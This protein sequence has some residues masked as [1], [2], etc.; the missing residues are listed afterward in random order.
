MSTYTIGLDFGTNSARAI[1]VDCM[2]GSIVGSSIYNYKFGEMGIITDTSNPNIAR[3]HPSDYI[4]ALKKIIPQSLAEANIKTDLVKGIGVDTT[5]STPI[6]VD[7]DGQA[8]ALNSSYE[9]NLSAM[10]WLWKDHTASKEAEEITN[11]AKKIRPHYLSKCGG[12]YSSEWYWAKLLHCLRT[13]PDVFKAAYSWVELQDW[14]PFVLTGE[15]TLGLCAAGHKGLYH[16]SWNGFP[17]DE[18]FEMLDPHLLDIRLTLPSSAKH[19]GQIAGKL[20]ENWATEFNLPL[21]TPVATGTIDA[22]AG[23][24]GSGIETGTMVKIIGTSTCDIVLSSIS[25]DL[26]EIPGICGIAEESVLPGYYGLEAGQS[27][28]G[29]I[30]NWFIHKIEPGCNLSHDDLNQQVELLNPG[31]SGLLALDWN[32]GNRSLLADPLLSGLLIGTTLHTTPAEIF[33]AYIEATAFGARMIIERFKEYNILIDR[34]INCGGIAIKSSVVMQIYADILGCEMEVSKNEQSCALGAAMAGAVVGNVHGDFKTAA[35]CMTG[36]NDIVY[37]PISD[38][39]LIYD[40]LYKMYKE[41]H[42]VF[43]KHQSTQ[44]LNHIMKNLI[45]IREEVRGD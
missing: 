41:L 40:K 18:F 13:A 22:H 29:D 6:P 36:T 24:V 39:Q 20:N 5:A 11:L 42:D 23:A 15:R 12:I 28:V 27:A 45:A 30:F 17:D 43:G 9:G 16:S 7:K 21:G 37:K 38:H 19:I 31:E 32:N 25:E 26:P 1:V 10:A 14:I 33:R 34:V 8:L 35:L 44:N 4:S 2:N 3:Q